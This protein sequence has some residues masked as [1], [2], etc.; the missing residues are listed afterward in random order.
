MR[1]KY[2]PAAII[3]DGGKGRAELCREDYRPAFRS[4]RSDK[5]ILRST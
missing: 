5:L 3:H 4:S 1:D 2:V